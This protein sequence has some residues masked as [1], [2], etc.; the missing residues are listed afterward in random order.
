[1][2]DDLQALFEQND[3]GI[4]D[5]VALRSSAKTI[6]ENYLDELEENEVDNAE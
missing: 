6:I 2:L 5:T 4:S 1:M 3:V